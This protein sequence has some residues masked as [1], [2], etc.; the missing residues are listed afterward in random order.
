MRGARR[1][2][3][4]LCA[5]PAFWMGLLYDDAALDAAWDLVKDFSW[6]S[7]MPCA[8]ACRATPSNCPSAA[9]VRDLCAGGAEDRRPGPGAAPA[10]QRHR[11]QRGG[12][13]RTADRVRPGRARPGRAQAGAVPSAPWQGN[14]DPSSA[15]SPTEARPRGRCR[16]AC[17]VART[18]APRQAAPGSRTHSLHAAA[19]YTHPSIPAAGRRAAFRCRQRSVPDARAPHP[20]ASSTRWAR[21][22]DGAGAPPCCGSSP[23]SAG[24]LNGLMAEVFESHLRG[25]SPH[26]PRRRCGAWGDVDA[27]VALVRRYLKKSIPPPPRCP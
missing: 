9:A 16:A 17:A 10:P 20:P 2:W 25:R 15:S 4:R 21:A 26:P 12:V 23:P 6:P 18:R 13:P 22:A 19:G 1:P 7:A 5:L 14:I 8:M 11:R 3:N 27:A 24:R